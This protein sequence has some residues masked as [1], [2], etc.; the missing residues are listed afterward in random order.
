MLVFARANPPKR[1][2]HQTI[3]R[4]SMR[5]DG[6]EKAVSAERLRFGALFEERRRSETA[7]KPYLL[8][9]LQFRSAV[10]NSQSVP[11]W[12][13]YRHQS[14]SAFLLRLRRSHRLHGSLFRT[15][16]F[17]R[18]YPHRAFVG[19]FFEIL[20]NSGSDG[21]RLLIAYSL[22]RLSFEK[23]VIR[24][25]RRYH[26]VAACLRE[27]LNLVVAASFTGLVTGR[28]SSRVCFLMSS[29]GLAPSSSSV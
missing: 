24:R 12:Y 21:L 27:I 1:T 22:K 29:A 8:N 4:S 14:I 18:R 20:Q 5:S 17:R 25:F 2:F 16:R 7:R 19:S 11:L 10:N 28:R 3:F 15:L 26:I 23:L 6:T 9:P 13:H